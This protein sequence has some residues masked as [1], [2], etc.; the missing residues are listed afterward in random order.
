MISPQLRS[1]FLSW[2][3]LANPGKGR[4]EFIDAAE[5]ERLMRE[6]VPSSN[7]SVQDM[8]YWFAEV[9]ADLPS[10]RGALDALA[11]ERAVILARQHERYRD[12]TKG[13]ERFEAVEPA[14]PPDI[15]GIYVF[16]LA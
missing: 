15:V 12:L 4:T 10:L 16:V 8:E 3:T 7:L 5:A 9:M 11:L 1:D 14:L 13:K 6:A 2:L